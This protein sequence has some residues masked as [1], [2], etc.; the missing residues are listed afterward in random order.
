M[1]DFKFVIVGRNSSNTHNPIEQA[2]QTGLDRM[3]VKRFFN[4]KK[5][6]S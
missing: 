5:F 3:A 1:M 6:L 4:F 2:N